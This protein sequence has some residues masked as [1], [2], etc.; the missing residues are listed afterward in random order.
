MT[1]TIGDSQ[2]ACKATACLLPSFD[3][4]FFVSLLFVVVVVGAVDF[5]AVSSSAFACA[6]VSGTSSVNV[7]CSMATAVLD[8]VTT[9]IVAASDKASATADDTEDSLSLAAAVGDAATGSGTFVAAAA[10]SINVSGAAASID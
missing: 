9:V 1:Q 2:S 5:A 8:F 7:A 3:F 6:N 4:A 10:A